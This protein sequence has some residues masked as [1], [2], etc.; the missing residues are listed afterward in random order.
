M[1]HPDTL[2]VFTGHSLGGERRT[3]PAGVALTKPTLRG[4]G[5][6]AQLAAMSFYKRAQQIQPAQS[7]PPSSAPPASALR[8]LLDHSLYC[9]TFAGAHS[10]E[11][12]A[13]RCSS[14]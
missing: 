6:L 5:A 11:L 1:D 4:P 14:R 9:I 10:C 8:L 12:N 7:S 2:L 3:T 13:P